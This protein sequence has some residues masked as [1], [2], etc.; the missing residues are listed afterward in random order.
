MAD[1]K[2]KKEELDI[3]FEI[4]FFEGLLK[5]NPDYVPALLAL[6]H[7]YTKKGEFKKGLDIDLRL[8]RLRRDEPLVHYNLACSYSLLGLLDEAFLAIKKAIDLGYE[9]IGYLLSDPDLENL[10]KDKRFD[11]LF[12]KLKKQ[13]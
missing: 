12:A 1:R 3:D 11:D 9:D 13:T 10:R 5:D 8:T 7:A 6:G 2:N 4:N